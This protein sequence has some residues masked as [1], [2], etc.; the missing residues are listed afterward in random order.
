MRAPWFR[1]LVVWGIVATLP[2]TA[3]SLIGPRGEFQVNTYTTGSQRFRDGQPRSTVCH[4][5]LGNFVT[6]WRSV[7][8]DGD[9][10]G[11]FGQRVAVGGGLLGSEFQVNTYTTGDQ[12]DASVCCLPDGGF[13]VVW[14]S[15]GG[16]DGDQ[17]GVFGQ[18]FDGSAARVGAEFPINTYTTANQVNVGV[19]CSPDGSFV[20]VWDGR[21]G[22][23]GSQRGIFG[24]R[25]SSSG[26]YAGA[27]FQVNTYTSG[28]QDS[29]SIC[30]DGD[31]NFVVAWESGR[32]Q[33]G[34][35][36]G[37]FAQ[38]FWSTGA[39]RGPEFQVNTFTTDFQTDPALC[40][41]DDGAFRV[42]WES[43]GDQDG[44]ERGVFARSYVSNGTPAGP[45]IQVNT[46]TT[47]NQ[48]EP[49][50]CCAPGGDFLVAWQS[51]DQDGA[52]SGIFS[53]L[54]DSN[55]GAVGTE[56]QVNTYTTGSQRF[57]FVSCS[58][59]ESA[60]VWDGPEQGAGAQRGIFATRFLFSTPESAAPAI[61]VGALSLALLTLAGVAFK[62]LRRH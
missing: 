60:V 5:G 31:G 13:V 44:S 12:E 30:C 61:G 20:S 18:R 35:E 43:L 62:A 1:G 37:V 36:S 45:P 58:P 11:V 59:Q 34:D 7:G 41:R 23:D 56:L 47:G 57:P 48:A 29:A 32:D 49:G 22:Q 10:E 17:T 27:E 4:D 54:F 25:F 55:D 9:G 33:D 15:H 40:C 14:E 38:R 6:V 42:A 19:C 26:A 3:L 28:D 2:P 16:Q 52:G 39:M 21:G 51:E 24:Q 46:Y 53:Q 50:I 8:Q